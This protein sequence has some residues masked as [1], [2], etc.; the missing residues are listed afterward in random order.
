MIP[1][2]ELAKLDYDILAYIR[3]FDGVPAEKIVKHVKGGSKEIMRQLEVLSKSGNENHY[4]SPGY[5]V[6]EFDEMTEETWGSIIR[7][8]RYIFHITDDGE[9][10]LR[11]YRE[12]NIAEWRRFLIKSVLV[13]IIVSV[14]VAIITTLAINILEDLF[15]QLAKP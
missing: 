3:R 11:I 15:P 12:K 9:N 6:D 1:M 2:S 14:I 5:I 8:P 10:A 7:K 4:Y 13:P